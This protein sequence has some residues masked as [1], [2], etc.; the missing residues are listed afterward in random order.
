[1]WKLVD[2]C[3]CCGCSLGGF[4]LRLVDVSAAFAGLAVHV[5]AGPGRCAERGVVGE[6]NVRCPVCCAVEWSIE[7]QW[8]R[9]RRIF[10]IIRRL[11]SHVDVE[12]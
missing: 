4:R 1:M 9:Y 10:N 11:C 8:R 12:G 7:C 2:G 5:R 3:G 6:W